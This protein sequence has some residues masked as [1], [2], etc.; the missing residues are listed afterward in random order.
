MNECV[1]VT[2]SRF[3][4]TSEEVRLL[5]FS[6][7]E[8]TFEFTHGELNEPTINGQKYLVYGLVLTCQYLLPNSINISVYL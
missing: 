2:L 3:S 7:L 4:F 1:T 6:N 8:N 5:I